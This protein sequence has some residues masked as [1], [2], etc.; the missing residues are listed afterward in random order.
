M[1]LTPLRTATQAR[2]VGRE[3][4]YGELLEPEITDANRAMVARIAGMLGVAGALGL[5]EPI[6]VPVRSVCIA[7]LSWHKDTVTVTFKRGGQIN[8]DYPCD[9]ETFQS[10]VN[11][12]SV[13]QFFNQ[14][15]K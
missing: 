8:Y 14:H 4:V 9:L 13:G 7:N 11:A 2:N 12:P 15:F 3:A 10:F 5:D 1:A 6:S